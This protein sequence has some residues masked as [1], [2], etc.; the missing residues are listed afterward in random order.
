M[1]AGL[2]WSLAAALDP[3]ILAGQL[4][5]PLLTLCGYLAEAW[6]SGTWRRWAV[7]VVL[8]AG[9]GAG[10]WVEPDL[11]RADAPAYYCY[12]RSLA[13]DHDIDFANEWDHWGYSEK[14]ITRCFCYQVLVR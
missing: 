2:A 13:F 12:L 5:G 1:I 8:A 10:A 11:L 3:A 9:Y 7:A 14:P 6:R 4:A